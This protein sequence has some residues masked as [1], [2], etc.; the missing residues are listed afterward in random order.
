MSTIP[1]ANHP[2]TPTEMMVSSVTRDSEG[3]E[4]GFESG[5][6]GFM[7]IDDSPVIMKMDVESTARFMP[8]GVF[9]EGDLQM[10]RLKEFPFTGS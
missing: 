3:L 2:S 6:A 4:F 7:A 9:R 8:S 10:S 5:S 1:T